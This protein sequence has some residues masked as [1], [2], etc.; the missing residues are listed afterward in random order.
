MVRVR[1]PCGWR[2]ARGRSRGNADDRAKTGQPPI[3]A[4]KISAS[5]FRNSPNFREFFIGPR[6]A[7]IYASMWGAV[8]F[9]LLIACANLA[10]LMLARA[11]SRSREISVRMALGAGRWPVIRQQTRRERD[12]VEPGR[13]VRAAG[14]L[15]SAG[16]AGVAAWSEAPWVV[17]FF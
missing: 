4:P 14:L 13:P 9:V 1:P 10:N 2:D 16:G 11:V 7:L 5:S 12:A 17:F 8:G 6:R 3:R 15:C